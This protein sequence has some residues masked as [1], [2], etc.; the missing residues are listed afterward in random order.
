MK[1]EQSS[2][3]KNA[4]DGLGYQTSSFFFVNS[5]YMNKDYVQLCS[6]NEAVSFL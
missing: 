5:I 3:K 2:L 6:G 4:I 1:Q